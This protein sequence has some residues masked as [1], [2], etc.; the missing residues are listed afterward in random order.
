MMPGPLRP[1]RYTNVVRLPPRP[2]QPDD[3]VPDAWRDE[4]EAGMVLVTLMVL[5][6][7]L[8]AGAIGWWLWVR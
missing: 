7:L 1:D 2:Y 5:C 3:E 6:V 4:A 8:A